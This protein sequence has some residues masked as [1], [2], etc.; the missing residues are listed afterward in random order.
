MHHEAVGCLSNRLDHGLDQLARGQVK[1]VDQGGGHQS[2][3][4][5]LPRFGADVPADQSDLA[6]PF[7][8]RFAKRLKKGTGTVVL[9]LRVPGD[10][11]AKAVGILD[12]DAIEVEKDRDPD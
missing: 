8:G 12:E 4:Q 1:G 9:A 11:V 5:A 2:L 6:P 10:L 7:F 3:G